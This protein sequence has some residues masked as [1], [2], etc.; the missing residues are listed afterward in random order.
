ML[1]GDRAAGGDAGLEDQ[2]GQLERAIACSG[3]G[4]VVE[5]ERVE[6]AVTGMEDVG[7]AQPVRRRERADR[8]RARRAAA[9]AGSPRPGRSSSG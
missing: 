9:C 8:T 7:D 1:T 6:V 3:L 4:V 2:P 5:H